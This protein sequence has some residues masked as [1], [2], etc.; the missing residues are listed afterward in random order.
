MS[1]ELLL[2]EMPIPQAFFRRLL[3]LLKGGHM[4]GETE[5]IHCDT[6]WSYSRI[7]KHCRFMQWW[8]EPLWWDEQ[9]GVRE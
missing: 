7:C 1:D 6:Y 8:N 4:Y 3:C 5:R 2:H 9:E